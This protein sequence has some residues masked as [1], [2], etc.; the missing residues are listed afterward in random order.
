MSTTAPGIKVGK[1]PSKPGSRGDDGLRSM[2]WSAPADTV[3]EAKVLVGVDQIVSAEQ[4]AIWKINPAPIWV[5]SGTGDPADALNIRPGYRAFL[6]ILIKDE[7]GKPIIKLWSM[8]IGCHRQIAEIA[9]ALGDIAG[10]IIRIKREGS[11]L[12]TKYS[13]LPIGKKVAITEDVPTVD[14]I[15]ELM[16]PFDREEI[17][18]KIE[19]ISK[20]PFDANFIKKYRQPDR[21]KEDK[22]SRKT[23]K[24]AAKVIEAEASTDIDEVDL[25]DVDSD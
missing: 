9:E 10:H 15:I 25:E 13:I 22:S 12:S 18:K 6:P 20:E 23:T 1:A 16:G 21:V 3:V 24:K 11:G 17:I 8:S 2:F 14:Q 19:A 5:Y 4:C 7:D